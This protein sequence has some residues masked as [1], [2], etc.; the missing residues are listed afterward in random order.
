[1]ALLLERHLA[2]YFDVVFVGLGILLFIIIF[3]YYLIHNRLLMKEIVEN[4]GIFEGE[5]GHLLFNYN[6]ENLKCQKYFTAGVYLAW[7]LMQGG[8]SLSIMDRT[9]VACM[10]NENAVVDVRAALPWLPDLTARQ[11]IEKVIISIYLAM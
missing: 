6:L 1:M 2:S 7:S 8:P 3:L 11:N 10:A 5:P 9:M 4:M